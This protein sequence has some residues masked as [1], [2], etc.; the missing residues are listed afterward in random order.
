MKRVKR[1]YYEI[2]VP[3]MK[4]MKWITFTLDGIEKFLNVMLMSSYEHADALKSISIEKKK[5]KTVEELRELKK[6]SC[7]F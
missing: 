1:V 3:E 4:K 6:I 5:Y 2:T 7:K